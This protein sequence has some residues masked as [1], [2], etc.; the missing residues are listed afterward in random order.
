[1]KILILISMNM[2]D[3]KSIYK[4][5]LIV[6]IIIFLIALIHRFVLFS[7]FNKNIRPMTKQEESKILDILNN[8]LDLEK[9]RVRFGN[10]G[11][12]SPKNKTAT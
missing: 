2:V 1:M 3:K 8:S 4:I 9:Y 7:I 5:V 12:C 6:F 11:T 10:I